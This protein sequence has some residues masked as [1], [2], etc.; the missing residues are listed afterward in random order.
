MPTEVTAFGRLLP[1]ANGKNQPK[2][3]DQQRQKST[4]RGDLVD[5]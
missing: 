2:A 3:A 1:V 5:V 4:K